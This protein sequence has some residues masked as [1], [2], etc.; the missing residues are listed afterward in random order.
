[1]V[2]RAWGPMLGPLKLSIFISRHHPKS[3][4]RAQ[5]MAR[6]VM[7]KPDADNQLKLIADALNEVVY[8]DDSQIAWLE[9]RRVYRPELAEHVE[10]TVSELGE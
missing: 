7:G 8:R 9:V 10:V 6:W 3:W 2:R 5:R 1:M 4:T